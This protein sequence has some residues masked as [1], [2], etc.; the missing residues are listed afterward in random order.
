[1]GERRRARH[2]HVCDAEFGR[3][4]ELPAPVEHVER[5]AER[6]TRRPRRI[7]RPRRR[8]EE[9]R[10]GARVDHDVM[11]DPVD[12]HVAVDESACLFDAQHRPGVRSGHHETPWMTDERAARRSSSVGPALIQS[13]PMHGAPPRVATTRRWLTGWLADAAFISLF[14][15]VKGVLTI[16]LRQLW[17]EPFLRLKRYF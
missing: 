2:G 1:M 11:I 17:E 5:I 15:I 10:R 4:H 16:A 6:V 9:C 14:A 8:N 3:D 12:H 13:I 7:A